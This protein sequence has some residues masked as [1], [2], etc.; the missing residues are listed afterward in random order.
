MLIAYSGLK[1]KEEKKAEIMAGVFLFT[2]SGATGRTIFPLMY[3]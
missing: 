3:C 1:K 2:H